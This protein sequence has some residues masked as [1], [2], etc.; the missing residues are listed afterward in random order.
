MKA[1]RKAVSEE[2]I[3]R[4]VISQ[5]DN[6]TA[7]GKP[8]KVR[9]TKLTSVSIPAA[10]AALQSQQANTNALNLVALSLR[11]IPPR[12]EMQAISFVNTRLLCHFMPRKDN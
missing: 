8:V 11:A 12:R 3:D 9:R 2:E 1:K 4:I 6:E 10:L 5:A 7:W